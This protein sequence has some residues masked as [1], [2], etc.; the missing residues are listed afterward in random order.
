MLQDE[1]CVPLLQ[2]SAI[3]DRMA[4]KKTP[5]ARKIDIDNLD[6]W[7]DKADVILP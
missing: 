3:D 6:V 5:I 7:I 2:Q 4:Q 1:L